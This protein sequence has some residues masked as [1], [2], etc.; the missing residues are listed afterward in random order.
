LLVGARTSELAA[1]PA[2]AVVF[3]PTLT[4]SEGAAGANVD[5]YL[6]SSA[7]TTNYGNAVNLT[8]RATRYTPLLRFDL[9]S[10]PAGS[11]CDSAA[12][13]LFLAQSNVGGYTM[14][15]HELLSANSAWTEDGATWNTVD[16]ANAWA[17][18]AGCSTAGTDYAS[19]N[20]GSYTG[21]SGD[22]YD[23]EYV[24]SLTPAAVAGWFG[25]SNSN[26]GIRLYKSD[27]F[28]S[29]HFR[30]SDWDQPATRPKLVVVYTEASGDTD[31]LTAASIATGAPSVGS[32]TLA[33]VHA[34]DASDVA[35]DAPVLGS[36]AITQVHA[37]TAGNIATGSPATGTPQITQAHA[38]KAGSIA[39]G[40]PTTG[41]PAL[42]ESHNLTAVSVATGAPIVGSPAI[43]Q[44]H[45]LVAGSIATGSPALT[46]PTI[47]QVHA[48]E[49]VGIATE[50]PTL[51]TPAANESHV[52]AANGIATGSP[53]LGT[54]VISQAHVLTAVAL[55]AGNP[56]VG[57]PAMRQAHAL[58]ATS[59]ATG[60]P[61]LGSPTLSQPEVVTPVVLYTLVDDSATYT[62][63]DDSDRY[64][65][66]DDSDR[67]TLT[68]I[69]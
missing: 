67:Y 34:L 50:A 68:A 24:W 49:A 53:T 69:G 1:L 48:L 46:A 28:V 16:G 23:T 3:D 9:S 26:Y 8:V 41:T 19:A 61:T 5:T 45:A 44:V 32:P 62:L 29:T 15:V 59:V 42:S 60:S 43:T 18:S 13:S 20:I 6:S 12:L 56:A 36:P 37:L 47:T 4:L 66:T 64:T 51:G 55:L 21:D 54:P 57:S 22:P 11:T 35:T 30:S 10:I 25:A 14:T 52:L 2:G 33:Q 39:T 40:A 63:T 31:E 65:L 17:G 7:A 58:L 27:E 38:L